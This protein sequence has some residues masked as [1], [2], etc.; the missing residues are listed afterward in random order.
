MKKSKKYLILFI[1]VMIILV[2]ILVISNNLAHKTDYNSE[3]EYV[4]TYESGSVGKPSTEDLE[5]MNQQH[6]EKEN[7]KKA[8]ITAATYSFDLAAETPEIVDSSF[9]DL[10]EMGRDEN[11]VNEIKRIVQTIADNFQVDIVSLKLV[12]TEYKSSFKAEIYLISDE[13]NTYNTYYNPE[14][15]KVYVSVDIKANTVNETEST[16]EVISSTEKDSDN[17]TIEKVD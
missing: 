17:F 3:V 7:N 10:Y 4:D 6:E 16:E 12:G 8:Y 2:V 14:D 5:I 13:Y 1:G 15:E 11:N 9:G